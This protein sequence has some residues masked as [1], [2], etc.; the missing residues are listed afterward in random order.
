M[1]THS[2]NN[3]T[4]DNNRTSSGQNFAQPSS[5]QNQIQ[6]LHSSIGNQAVQKLFS[7]GLIQAK[8][9]I[10]SPNDKYEQEADRVAEQ[11]MNMPEQAVVQRKADKKE[12]IQSKT[13]TNTIEPVI[14]RQQ[15]EEEEEFQLGYDQEPEDLTQILESVP[16]GDAD[17]L[18]EEEEEFIQL[19]SNANTVPQITHGISHAIHS[20]KGS[21]QPLPISERAF[22]EPR[23]GTDFSNVRMHT[24]EQAART[25]QSINARAFTLG[26][27]LVFGAG[28]YLPGSLKGRSLLAHE[29]THVVQQGGGVSEKKGFDPFISCICLSD[30]CM[31]S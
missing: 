25:T 29:L 9:K 24:G 22:F 7:Q 20:I 13:I 19:K 11:V 5:S 2:N 30:I 14:Q 10:G 1:L 3:K 31:R 16:T 4:V 28:Q 15:E 26:R 8:L 27:D 21:E 18:A 23:F 17:V 6:Q 12:L